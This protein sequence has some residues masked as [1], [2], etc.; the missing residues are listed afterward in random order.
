MSA[1]V[2][3]ALLEREKK[4]DGEV[5]SVGR[6]VTDWEVDPVG[7]SAVGVAPPSRDPEGMREG[8]T[9]AVALSTPGVNVWQVLAVGA[10]GV[11]VD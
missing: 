7:K 5:L 1:G 11:E 2:N 4:S 6:G 10:K 8:V 9:S 3:V